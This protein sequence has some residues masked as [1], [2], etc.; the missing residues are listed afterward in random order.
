MRCAIQ[1]DVLPL[2]LPP[3]TK[4][5]LLQKYRGRLR[6]C[7]VRYIALW[8]ILG[9]KRRVDVWSLKLGIRE[10][11]L[12]VDRRIFYRNCVLVVDLKTLKPYTSY[13]GPLTANLCSLVRL[14][15]LLRGVPW[16]PLPRR[17][18]SNL[19]CHSR[20]WVLYR[21]LPTRVW[22]PKWTGPSPV[23]PGR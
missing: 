9:S 14:S 3:P 18:P 1:I 11:T 10:L 12:F 20:D 4:I 8:D 13:T 22:R 5:P 19:I 2:P 15:G 21:L 7:N 16:P 17:R 6:V 23:R